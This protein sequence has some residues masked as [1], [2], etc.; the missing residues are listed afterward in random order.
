MAMNC[1]SKNRKMLTVNPKS[2][3]IFTWLIAIALG[4]GYI[5][6]VVA[7]KIAEILP[8]HLFSGAFLL[9]GLFTV[10]YLVQ[11]PS[12]I[13]RLVKARA[14]DVLPVVLLFVVSSFVLLFS[15][16]QTYLDHDDSVIKL[17][18]IYLPT[19]LMVRSIP[20][21]DEIVNRLW[22]LAYVIFAFC[23]YLLFIANS[24]NLSPTQQGYDTYMVIGYQLGLSSILLIENYYHTKEK[25]IKHKLNLCVGVIAFIMVIIYG[26]RGTLIVCVVYF[27]H[28]V[29]ESWRKNKATKQMVVVVLGF[30][31]VIVFRDTILELVLS[32]SEAFGVKSRTVAWLMNQDS[33]IAS[34]GRDVIYSQAFISIKD[35]PLFGFGLMGDRKVLGG[36]S[37]NIF[38]ELLL[39]Y[40]LFFGSILSLC[41]VV[42]Y[43]KSM[44]NEKTARINVLV[45]FGFVQLLFSGSY[46]HNGSFWVALGIVFF[47]FGEK[48][49]KGEDYENSMA[50]YCG[51]SNNI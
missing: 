21:Y 3:K 51:S 16:D 30:I 6:M 20:N 44:F 27:I 12:M 29:I 42:G 37:H 48:K 32:V 35:E 28:L 49:S 23:I 31:L 25:K 45:V 26:S 15:G 2:S 11:F 5:M 34:S 36:Y 7:N 46:A 40:G 47:V 22:I 17:L 18:F 24:E 13:N 19:F 41:I 39:S 4:E 8:F 14:I 50:K 43:F 9:Y 33:N 38:L 1:F 10:L